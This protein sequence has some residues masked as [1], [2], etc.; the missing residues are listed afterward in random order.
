MQ[1]YSHKLENQEEMTTK[2]HHYHYSSNLQKCLLGLASLLF[3]F[4]LVSM[5]FLCSLP[6]SISLRISEFP[7]HLSY[8]LIFVAECGSGNLSAHLKAVNHRHMPIFLKVLWK[9]LLFASCTINLLVLLCHDRP[10]VDFGWNCFHDFGS[11]AHTILFLQ[12]VC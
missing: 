3:F 1:E 9:R 6:I 4:F 12:E 10:D 11:R 5:L 7:K 8:F 2:N